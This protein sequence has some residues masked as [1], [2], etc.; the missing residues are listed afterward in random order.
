[1][2]DDYIVIK[3]IT[4]TK[5]AI[6]SENKDIMPTLSHA[7][8]LPLVLG[9]EKWRSTGGWHLLRKETINWTSMRVGEHKA[10]EEVRKF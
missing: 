8:L 1:M 4:D 9:F 5:F 7:I 3:R 10:F 6:C 2:E